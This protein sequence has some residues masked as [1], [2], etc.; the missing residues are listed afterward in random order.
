MLFEW[1]NQKRL[2]NLDKHG[3]D[4]A[5]CHAMFQDKHA[6]FPD[7]RKAYGEDRYNA[8]WRL[9]GRLVVTTFVIREDAIRIISARKANKREEAAYGCKV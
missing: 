6:I 1:D 5:A 8:F 7:K 4:F 9:D 2:A 3:L